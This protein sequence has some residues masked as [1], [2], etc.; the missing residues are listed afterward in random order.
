M[1]DFGNIIYILIAIGWFLMNAYKKSQQKK[2]QQAE[3]QYQG[4]Q[5]DEEHQSERTPAKSLQD[6]ILEQLGGKVEETQPVVPKPMAHKNED[7]F[8]STDLTHSHLPE[9]Y[10]MGEGEMRSHRVERQ[11]RKVVIEEKEE[12]SLMDRLLPEGFDLRQAVVLNAI[13]DRPYK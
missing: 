4:G 13:L 8:L 3:K 5:V 9:D 12:E 2:Q 7:K 11:V 1:E 6:M 10:K